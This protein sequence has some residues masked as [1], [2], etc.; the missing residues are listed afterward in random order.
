MK[1]GNG[2]CAASCVSMLV[3]YAQLCPSLWPKMSNG[4]V[5]VYGEILLLHRFRIIQLWLN[6]QLIT[7]LMVILQTSRKNNKKK[8]RK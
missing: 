6:V 3:K 7:T 2:E 1:T 5:S 4:F 8:K